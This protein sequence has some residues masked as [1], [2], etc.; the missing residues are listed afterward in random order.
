M[1]EMSIAGTG[2][3]VAVEAVVAADKVVSR[4]GGHKLVVR[5]LHSGNH[6][7]EEGKLY[8]NAQKQ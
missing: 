2:D 4:P 6:G 8:S 3:L 7:E 1:A 5:G